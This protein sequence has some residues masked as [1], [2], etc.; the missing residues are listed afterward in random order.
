MGWFI[1][2]GIKGLLRFGLLCGIIGMVVEYFAFGHWLE[3]M[4]YT[5]VW[6]VPV[7]V[8]MIPVCVVAAWLLFFTGGGHD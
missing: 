3:I 2:T 7:W 1:G 8:Y 6:I 4:L 5:P